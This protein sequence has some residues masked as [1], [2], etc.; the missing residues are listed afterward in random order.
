MMT[1]SSRRRGCDELCWAAYAETKGAYQAAEEGSDDEN[2]CS[3]AIKE[4]N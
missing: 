2:R 4:L 3:E 1:S